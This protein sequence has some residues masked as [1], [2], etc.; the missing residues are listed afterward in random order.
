[1]RG[2][3][4]VE[5]GGCI[6]NSCY[7]L[8]ILTIYPVS[9]ILLPMDTDY[10]PSLNAIASFVLAVLRLLLGGFAL[11]R[12]YAYIEAPATNGSFAHARKVAELTRADACQSRR[13]RAFG[14][15]GQALQQVKG[16]LAQPPCGLISPRRDCKLCKFCKL[17]GG[18]RK[19]RNNGRRQPIYTHR[20]QSPFT[21]THRGKQNRAAYPIN[22]LPPPA[23]ATRLHPAAP[24]SPQ[25]ASARQSAPP[26]R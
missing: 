7:V 11:E 4:S 26:L 25:P 23:P 21:R 15:L 13:C 9:V 16:A 2:E 1:M 22:P 14:K 18:G 5:A 12:Q 3:V 17:W 10:T 20:A 19:G 8:F 6:F 24:F